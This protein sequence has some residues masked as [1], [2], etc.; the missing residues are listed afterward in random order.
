MQPAGDP[1]RNRIHWQC[2]RGMR[3]LDELLGRFMADGYET[4][5]S[6]EREH[7]VRLLEYPDQL[8]LSWFMG[9]AV[10]ADG[11]VARLVRRIRHTTAA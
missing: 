10:P 4:L 6:R 11:D 1:Q 2:R 8:L 7:L 5:D 9:R 3:E